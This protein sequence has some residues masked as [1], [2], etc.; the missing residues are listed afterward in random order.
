MITSTNQEIKDIKESNE[1]D[2][3]AIFEELKIIKDN[4]LA[5]IEKSMNCI[6]NRMIEID[7]N[8]K[9][10]LKFFWIVCGAV[11]SSLA[12]AVLGLIAKQ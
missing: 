6:E 7:T 10:Q 12:V 8:Q 2:H 9:W 5:H 1:K 4:H 11:L 3:R